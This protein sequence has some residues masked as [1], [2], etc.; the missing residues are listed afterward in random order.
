MVTVVCAGAEAPHLRKASG[1]EESNRARC[2]PSRHPSEL[3][4]SARTY[5]PQF[6]PFLNSQFRICQWINPLMKAKPSWSSRFLH[7]GHCS[8]ASEQCF[9]W[10]QSLQCMTVGGG[11]CG[12]AIASSVCM[13]VCACVPACICGVVEATGWCLPQLLPH[14]Q[15]RWSLIRPENHHF[16]LD[17]PVSRRLLSTE[18]CSTRHTPPHPVFTQMLGLNSKHFTHWVNIFFYSI[19][20]TIA[21]Y[22]A[23]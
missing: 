10:G 12:A 11:C 2:P 13:C 7:S 6:S 3:L 19:N 15:N 22:L 1:W 8:Q 17:R 21:Y 9:W 20:R 4:S 16:P 18:C 23:L 14:L 5:L